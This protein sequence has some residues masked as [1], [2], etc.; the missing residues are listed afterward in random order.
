MLL[1]LLSLRLI[2]GVALDVPAVPRALA[3]DLVRGPDLFVWPL[4][5]AQGPTDLIDGVLVGSGHTAADRFL[6]GRFGTHPVGVEVATAE[7]RTGLVMTHQCLGELGD[8]TSLIDPRCRLP[9]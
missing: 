9:P 7:G 8:L 2:G 5:D 6:T 1:T 4:L 3:K